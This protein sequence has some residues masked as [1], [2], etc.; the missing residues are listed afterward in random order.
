[1]AFLVFILEEIKF[2]VLKKY[3]WEYDKIKIPLNEIKNIK[4]FLQNL[5]N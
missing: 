2:I 1:V 4:A 5:L 3:M